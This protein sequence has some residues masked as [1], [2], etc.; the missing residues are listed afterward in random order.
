[1]PDW[2]ALSAVVGLAALGIT[3]IGHIVKTAA[4]NGALRQRVK[5]AEQ[6]LLSLRVL[7]SN[8]DPRPELAALKATMEAVKESVA[9]L[10]SDTHASFAELNHIIRNRVMGAPKG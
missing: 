7:V 4:D 9:S 6:E 1:M 8:S 10:K 3:Q 2:E 5:T